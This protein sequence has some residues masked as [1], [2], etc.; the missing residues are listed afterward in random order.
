[1]ADAAFA[2][3]AGTRTTGLAI[4]RAML[5]A[6]QSAVVTVTEPS[7][8]VLYASLI[9]SIAQQIGALRLRAVKAPSRFPVALELEAASAALEGYLG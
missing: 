2:S 4:L 3:A 8:R 7:Y 1:M 6:Y 5:G 9:A